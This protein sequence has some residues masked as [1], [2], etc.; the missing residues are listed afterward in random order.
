MESSIQVGVSGPSVWVRVEGRGTF[1]NSG[2]LKQFAREM[3]ER[4]YREF[5]VDLHD[6]AMM[7]STFMGTMAGLA[8]RLRELGDG[9][10]Q[11]VHCGQR[12]RDLLAG[13]GLDQLFEITT[14]GA[15]APRCQA[16]EKPA[17]DKHEQARQMLDA[18]EALCEVAPENVPRF[19]DVLEYLKQDLQP[20][21]PAK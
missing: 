4:G 15:H 8:L 21:A 14:N 13:L 19:K 16:L 20:K 9:N 5:V 1:L 6:C 11:V 17:V 18:H 10:L 2:N 12:S 3:V 7:D